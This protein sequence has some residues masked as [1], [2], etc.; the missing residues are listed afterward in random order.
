MT[1]I[2]QGENTRVPGLYYVF[3]EN[4]KGMDKKTAERNLRE[5]RDIR[6][7]RWMM[8][9]AVPLLASALTLAITRVSLE[10]I[11]RFGYSEPQNT[12][13]R[14][15]LSNLG[16]YVSYA[17]TGAVVASGAISAYVGISI[18]R[19]KKR[20]EALLVRMEDTK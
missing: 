12:Q 9:G 3:N 8:F 15:V 19:R 2:T 4:I 20:D 11:S 6:G 10:A 14:Q 18:N 16:A 7:A 5:A 17:G 13:V 1:E